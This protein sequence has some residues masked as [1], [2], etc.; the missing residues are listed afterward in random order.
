LLRD[1]KSAYVLDAA[2][3]PFGRRGGALAAWHPVDLAAELN[4]W[5]LARAGIAPASVG[6]VVLGCVSQVGA[7]AYNL[8]RRAVLAAGWP[9]SVPGLTVDCHAASSAQAVHLSAAAVASGAHGLVVACGVEVMTAVPL[10][11][12]LAHP[13]VGKPIGRR[14]AERYAGGEGLPPPGLAAEEVAKRWKLSRADLDS[15]AASSYKKA[16]R[17]QAR[18]PAYLMPLARTDQPAMAR[19]EGLAHVP[20][21]AEL[22]ALP[23]AYV[24]GGVVTAANMAGEGDGASAVVV[25]SPAVAARFGGAPK[26]RLVAFATAGASPG[27]W[28]VASLPATRA[29]LAMAGIAPAGVDSWFVHESSS[30]AVLAW[31]LEMKVPLEQVN[32]DGGALASTSPAGAVGAGLFVMAVDYLAAGRGERALVCVAGEGGVGTACVLERAE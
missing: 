15:W 13:A 23:P 3:T 21:K 20:T 7:Q 30:A 9:E 28:P 1:T 27:L 24:T 26:A 19:D 5:L 17:A 6:A 18:R 2:R 14:L 12:S 11:A 31:A 4:T 10:G 25:A 16:L 32:P 8:G 29:A 22:R